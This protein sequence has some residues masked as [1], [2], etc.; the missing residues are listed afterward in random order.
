MAILN[1]AQLSSAILSPSGEQV[2]LQTNSNTNS[3]NNIDTDILITKTSEKNWILPSKQITVT[4]TI[5]NN[6]DNNISNINFSD[7]ISEGASF[8]EGSV[9]IGSVT[10]ANLDVI[11]GFTMPVTLGGSGGELSLSY[12]IVA[13]KY[14]ISDSFNNQSTISFEMDSKTFTLSSNTLNIT[15]VNNDISILKTANTTAVKSGDI[16]TYT[17]NITNSGTYKNTNLIFT[18]N[19][20]ENTEFVENSVTINSE[21]KT[22]F[23]PADS[24]ELPDLEI[25]GSITITFKVSVK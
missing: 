18:D 24:F 13:D 2:S 12:Q 16:I 5:V 9:K 19:I 1:T 20:P 23:N 17:I 21:T 3:I 22:G 8:V 7:T 4:T 14:I 11:S 15:I 6:T 25:D 10:Y